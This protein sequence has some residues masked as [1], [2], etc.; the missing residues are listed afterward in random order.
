M[1]EGQKDTPAPQPEPPAQDPV[2]KFLNALYDR[3][4]K[5][6][7][8]NAVPIRV[9]A[10]IFTAVYAAISGTTGA[11]NGIE[12]HTNA[13]QYT[14]ANLNFYTYKILTPPPLKPG[15]CYYV[16]QTKSVKIVFREIMLEPMLGKIAEAASLGTFESPIRDF[17]L[18][19]LPVVVAAECS[20]LSPETTLKTMTEAEIEIARI[21][22]TFI[23]ELDK[24]SA[25]VPEGMGFFVTIPGP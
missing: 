20:K 2:R 19:A 18:G 25:P 15:Q 12:A 11:V 17:Q 14:H 22:N 3:G 1:N 24:K 10:G 9:K 4:L 7:F 16:D 13:E 23:T 5:F 6:I 21:K 8:S